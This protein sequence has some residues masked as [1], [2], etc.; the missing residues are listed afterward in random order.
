MDAVQDLKS[1]LDAPL[2]RALALEGLLRRLAA[3]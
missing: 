3:E 2:N 1:S